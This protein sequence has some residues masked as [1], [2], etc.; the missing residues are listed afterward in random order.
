MVNAD[1]TWMPAWRICSF[2]RSAF[3]LEKDPEASALAKT[4]YPSA[5][6]DRAAN[7]VQTYECVVGVGI[8]VC[9]LYV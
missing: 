4:V 9:T 8:R 5:L 7:A 6:R 2:A 1:S 3:D